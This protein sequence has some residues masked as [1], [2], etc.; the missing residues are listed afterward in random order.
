MAPRQSCA[1]L[2][3]P[4]V[5]R[6]PENSSPGKDEIM[7]RLIA[8]LWIGLAVGAVFPQEKL[9]LE[10]VNASPLARIEA[11]PLHI[12]GARRKDSLSLVVKNTSEKTIRKVFLEF[13]FKG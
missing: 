1:P 7:K 8:V 9:A 11:A 6:L 2:A 3:G 12:D 5:R 10:I 4:G 13:K